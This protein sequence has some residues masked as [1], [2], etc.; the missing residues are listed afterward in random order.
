MWAHLWRGE[1]WKGEVTNCRKDG[2]E[3]IELMNASPVR[4]PNGQISNYLAIKENITEKRD[5]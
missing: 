1:L 2:T 5:I 4:Q 3:Y